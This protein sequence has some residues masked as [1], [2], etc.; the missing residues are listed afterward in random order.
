ML[1]ES[2]RQEVVA[3]NLANATTTGYKR[4]DSNTAPFESALLRNMAMPGQPE[5][6]VANFGSQVSRLDVVND[7]GALR[8]TGN[9]L[10]F[11]LVGDGW[12]AVD[13]PGGVRYTRDGS[14]TLSQDGTLTTKEGY[15]VLGENGPIR[16]TRSSAVGVQQ[17]GTVSQDG[18]I[19]GR[20]RITK[21]SEPL[22][23]EGANLVNGT[24]A[25]RATASVR[26][27]YLEGSTV[28]VVSEMVE[29]IRVMRSFEA[30]QKAVQAQ[31]ETLVQTLT[32]V[33]VV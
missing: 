11:A 4:T 19:V 31:D 8:N 14:F 26:Q 27:S 22:V 7:Q 12:F 29:L 6:G 30:N 24:A 20:M 21:L 17:D 32:K 2:V 3:N 10:D 18:R 16:L 15:A 23:K 25:G 33:G 9:Q 13:A 5:V 1:A 28:N